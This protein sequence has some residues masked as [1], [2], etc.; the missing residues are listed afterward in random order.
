MGEF[1]FYSMAIL[2]A[3]TVRGFPSLGIGTAFGESPVVPGSM[4]PA[5]S[6]SCSVQLLSFLPRSCSDSSSV[7]N[8]G[9]MCIRLQPGLPLASSLLIVGS[10]FWPPFSSV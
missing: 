2:K 6:P 9:P 4:A 3:R 7:P 10:Y 8:T 1:G 5:G